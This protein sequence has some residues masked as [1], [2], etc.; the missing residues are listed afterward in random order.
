MVSLRRSSFHGTRNNFRCARRNDRLSVPRASVADQ[1]L[2][3]VEKQVRNTPDVAFGT[4]HP[5]VR[6]LASAFVVLGAG[7]A[8]FTAAP[9]KFAP[10]V[11]GATGVTVAAA[12]AVALKDGPRKASR[13]ALAKAIATMGEETHSAVSAIP[14][15][16]G[17]EEQEF[18]EMKIEMYQIYLNAVVNKPGV[19]FGE[20]ADLTRLKYALSLDGAA[21]GDAHFEASRAFYRDNVLYLDAEKGDPDREAS[22]AKLSKLVFLSDR[23]YADKDTDEAYAYERSRIM[24]FFNLDENEYARRCSDIAIPFYLDVIDRATA[25]LSV[26][27]EDI[28][29][30]QAALGVKDQDATRERA[31]FYAETVENLVQKKGKLDANDNE[32]LARLRELFG[33]DEDRATSTLKTLAAP[34]YREVVREALDSIEGDDAE[35]FANVFGKL[36]LRQQELNLPAEAARATLADEF[37]T[38]GED[39]VRRASKYLRVQNMNGC[40]SVIKELLQFSER[41]IGLVNAAEVNGKE[42]ATILKE[43]LQRASIGLSRTEPQQMYR[44][45]LSDCLSDRK[46]DEKEE[47]ELSRLR[48]ILGLGEDETQRAYK[49]AA[50]PV[51]RKMQFDALASKDFSDENKAKIETVRED[52]GLPLDLAKSICVDLYK[53]KLRV[54]TDGNRIIQESEAQDLFVVR[55]FMGLDDDDTKDAHMSIMGPI[56]EQSVTEAMGPTGILLE[57]YRA[58]LERLRNRLN[59]HE[60]DATAVFN[61][62]VKQRMK[63]YVDRAMAQLEK[64]GKF[65]GQDAE[66]DMGDDPNIKRAGATLGMDTGGLPIELSNL[67]EFYVRNKLVVEEEIEVEGEKRTITKYP[68][69]LKDEI[70]PKIYNELYKQYLVQC[71]SASSRNE[72]QRLFAALD[73]LGSIL[74]M[75]EAEVAA[76]HANIGSLIYKN[77]ANN[78]LTKGPL[79]SKDV[80]FLANIEKML[81][82]KPD[83][84]KQ[85]LKEVKENR[86]SVL[87]EQLFNSNKIVPESIKK[88]RETARL[89]E[90]D[91][92]RDLKISLDR[93]ARLFT[94][95]ID[96]AIDRGVLTA[97]KQEIVDEVKAALQ[98][99]EDKAKEVLLD[100]IQR[101]SLNHLVQAAASL[102]QERS[103]NAVSELRSM[104]RYGK[105]LPTKVVAPAV[106]TG[107]KQELFLLFQAFVITDSGN[108]SDSAKEQIDLL[109]TMFGFS[110]ADLSAVV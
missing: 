99:P 9:Q 107:E 33:I 44:I 78:A 62:V 98:V 68:I 70:P 97:E 57:N 73:Q 39:I 3:R 94:V 18:Y 100:C 14:K 64:R 54:V 37:S 58:G 12:G 30:A 92:V 59:L 34:V 5:I 53:E 16:F 38:R 50:G 1:A 26:S 65:R 77:Y 21:I 63:V 72:K 45:Y 109:K 13:R 25:D 19:T 2:Q 67:V 22:Q 93:R 23:L 75:S 84:G 89:L 88:A 105:L 106:S 76:I 24:R 15:S 4:L 83:Q 61:K 55:R 8:S 102:R 95:E 79:E 91:I 52:L 110:D 32:K 17:V 11:A 96:T 48:V 49:S 90:V 85:I 31:D 43:Y 108:I 20:V 87:F 82:M 60:E 29:A 35:S 41:V 104:L 6:R 28:M 81:S 101:R 40:V 86:V 36:A 10:F 51:Y 56:Y 103:E 66:R 27:K 7:T 46:V 42:D 69:T 74:G 80:E 47:I 71:F